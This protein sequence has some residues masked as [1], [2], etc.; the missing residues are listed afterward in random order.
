MDK[1]SHEE[2]LMVDKLIAGDRPSLLVMG[3][4]VARALEKFGQAFVTSDVLGRVKIMPKEAVSL[5]AKPLLKE[6]DLDEIEEDEAI[7]LMVKEGR[8]ERDIIAYLARR[9]GKGS[10]Q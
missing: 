10:A 9:S 8:E 6:E 3:I 2:T 1:K 4:T 5:L 7:R